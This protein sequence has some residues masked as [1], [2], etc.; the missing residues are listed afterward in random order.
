MIIFCPLPKTLQIIP[1]PYPTNYPISCSLSMHLSFKRVNTKQKTKIKAKQNCTHTRMHVHTC[2]IKQKCTHACTHTRTKPKTKN[3]GACFMLAT[4]SSAWGLPWS[5][6]DIPSVTHS[7]EENG[8]SFSSGYQLQTPSYLRVG[9]CPLPL[10]GLGLC[11]ISTH[12]GLMPS[13][14]YLCEFIYVTI[15]IFPWSHLSPLALFVLVFKTGLLC[16]V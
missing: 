5:V 15:L 14:T 1:P 3:H 10:S 13:I 9:F 6:S 7:I 8:F 11:L 16:V 4:Y 2:T 12:S